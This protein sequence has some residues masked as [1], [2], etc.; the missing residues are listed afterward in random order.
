MGEYSNDVNPK[1]DF[2]EL[3]LQKCTW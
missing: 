3:L 1:Y 2:R